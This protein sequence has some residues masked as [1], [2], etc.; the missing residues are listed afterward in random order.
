MADY[1]RIKGEDASGKTH[2]LT[3]KGAWSDLPDAGIFTNKESFDHLHKINA[4][5]LNLDREDK[6]HALIERAK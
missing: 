4:R 6:I 5:N 3:Q 1:Y 2:W